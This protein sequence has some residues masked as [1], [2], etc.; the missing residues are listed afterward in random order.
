MALA[1]MAEMRG[2]KDA[3]VFRRSLVSKGKVEGVP[4]I[5]AWPNT[6]MNHSGQAAQELVNYYKVPLSSVLV[7][8]DDMDLPLGRLKA[9]SGGGSAGHNG[10]NS[11]L[12]EIGP[13]FDRLRIGIGRPERSIFD[14]DWAPYVLSPFNSL[15]VELLDKTLITAAKAAAAW[16][17]HGL[18]SAQRRANVRVK[19]PKADQ[20]EEEPK[21][22]GPKDDPQNQLKEP[23]P[24]DDPQNQLK[25]PGPKS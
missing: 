11:L 17:S 20:I 14:G 19:P 1:T 15:E 8:H 2:F 4:V 5:L 10:L 6:F 23:G 3:V 24:K 9:C 7:I 18:S 13:G 12:D 25:E 22:A 16:I 21:E